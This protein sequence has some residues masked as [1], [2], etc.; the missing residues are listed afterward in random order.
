M[1]NFS[2]KIISVI[3][4]FNMIQNGDRILVGLSGG[5]DS[6]ALLYALSLISDNLKISV[7]AAHLNHGIRGE[8]ALR[9]KNHSEKFAL[10]LG[11][12]FVS[13]D[14]CVPEYAKTHK[15]SEEMAARV[16]RY[17]FF[18]EAC[19]EYNCN[20]IAVAHNKNDSIET[21]L[22][23]IIRGSGSKA[24]DGIKPVN[25]NIIRPL[26][27]TSREEIEEF[28]A[29]NNI[30]YVTDSTNLEDSY[31]RNIVRN[32]IFP[33]MKMINENAV[34]NILRT[35]SIIRAE[36]EYIENE[37]KKLGIVWDN[38]DSVSI[39]R[40]EFSALNTALARRTLMLAIDTLCGNTLNVSNS[41][42]DS[43]ISNLKTGNIFS[44]GNGSKALIT[45]NEITLTK[46]IDS[47]PEY[48]YEITLP[49]DLYVKESGISYS[50]EFTD[51]YK[52]AP[53][54][55]FICADNLDKITVRTR[56]DGDTFVPYGMKGTKKVKSFYIDSKIPSIK[57]NLYP[58]VVS[59][60][61]ILA[62]LPLR[63]NDE[64][65][66]TKN[67]KKILRISSFGGT[68]DKT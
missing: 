22:L 61:K 46:T 15:L 7:A 26:I 34:N 59:N 30:D 47:I 25:S 44:F 56:K 14:V 62:V 31:A 11:I 38:S 24:M 55:L 8:E 41:Q 33:K 19:D 54:T 51:V 60:N 12:P 57:R 18:K 5:A 13:K 37:A 29:E 40:H 17:D 43:V 67:T 28:L 1:L 6:T 35:S 63:I 4:K 66:I 45:A 23:N 9:D 36:S 68:Y 10:R 3:K 58:V 27:E 16:L 48:E 42:I 53:N 2:D 64:F 32:H 65:K 20:K 50:F 21:I 39:K 49:G 52:P